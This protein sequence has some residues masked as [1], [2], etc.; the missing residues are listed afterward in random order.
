[1]RFSAK[2]KK[3]IIQIYTYETHHKQKNLIQKI[4]TKKFRFYRLLKKKKEAKIRN[5]NIV[6][7]LLIF[8]SEKN[9][10]KNNTNTLISEKLNKIYCHFFHIP[11][12]SISEKD[13]SKR[14]SETNLSLSEEV[15]Q[16]TN[17]I[18]NES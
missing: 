14:R 12:Y 6:P 2:Q 10:R 1:M 9:R 16:K 8:F 3:S 7:V 18:I 11:P 4:K 13:G 15:T 5:T 17:A